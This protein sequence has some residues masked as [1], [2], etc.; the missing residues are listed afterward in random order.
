MEVEELAIGVTV[1]LQVDTMM[2][3]SK[4]VDTE[5]SKCMFV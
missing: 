5:R 4:R 1:E 2:R 3:I